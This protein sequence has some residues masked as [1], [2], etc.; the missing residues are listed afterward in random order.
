MQLDRHQLIMVYIHFKFYEIS[1]RGYLVLANFMD[2]NQFKD[3]NLCTTKAS[4]TKLDVHYIV[5]VIHI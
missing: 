4:L 2:L 3:Y 1:F 5:I